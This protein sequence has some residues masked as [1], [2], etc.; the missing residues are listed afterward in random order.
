MEALTRG[1][2]VAGLVP[3]RAGEMAPDDAEAGGQ[4]RGQVFRIGKHERHGHVPPWARL[5][6]RQHTI[7]D[8]AQSRLH[9]PARESF[10]LGLLVS[11]RT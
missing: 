3:E 9:A 6:P 4:V 5:H 2:F 10:L 8:T 11:L 1:F 7:P